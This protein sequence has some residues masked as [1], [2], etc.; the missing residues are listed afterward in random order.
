MEQLPNE[1]IENHLTSLLTPIELLNFALT[2]NLYYRLSKNQLKI[3]KEKNVS[4]R[5]IRI[6]SRLQSLES[7]FK[8]QK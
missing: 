5:M 3:N 1:I 2:N 4:L 6:L 7:R 8:I